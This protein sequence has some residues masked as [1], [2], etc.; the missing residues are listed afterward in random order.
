MISQLSLFLKLSLLYDRNYTY[1]DVHVTGAET[2][3][4]IC[5]EQGVEK[6]VH[7]SAMNASENVERTL[8]NK[9]S[10]F[11]LSKVTV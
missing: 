3:A 11:L 10:R 1:E 6:L 9:Q 5:A 2:I 8:F 4:R 7:V